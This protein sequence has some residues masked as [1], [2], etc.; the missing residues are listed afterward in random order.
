MVKR[1][2]G[3]ISYS[4]RNERIK[5][6]FI[7]Q[8]LPAPVQRTRRVADDLKKQKKEYKTLPIKNDTLES[9]ETKYD[10]LIS[11][12]EHVYLSNFVLL[13]F[14]EI[15]V[16]RLEA[17]VILSEDPFRHNYVLPRRKYSSRANKQYTVVK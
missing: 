10:I 15:F 9:S 6:W 11:N 8:I 12:D 4:E 14:P 2:I 5:R 17:F 1:K 3:K 7:S 16:T 13:R